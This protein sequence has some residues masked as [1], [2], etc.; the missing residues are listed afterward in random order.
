MNTK[1]MITMGEWQ[2]A[3]CEANSLRGDTVPEGWM[4]SIQLVKMLG[5]TRSRA[6]EKANILVEAGKAERRAFCVP[7]G[8]TGRVRSV[9]HW[10][11]K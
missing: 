9:I 1:K 8:V 11:L 3:L 6:S 2:N 5:V 4:T 7:T 10:R